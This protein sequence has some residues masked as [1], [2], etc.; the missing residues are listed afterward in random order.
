[1][2]SPLKVCQNGACEP[3]SRR[4]RRRHP[5]LS[6][7]RNRIAKTS[8]Q[9]RFLGVVPPDSGAPPVRIPVRPRPHVIGTRFDRPVPCRMPDGHFRDPEHWPHRQHAASG[10]RRSPR[11][12]TLTSK[13]LPRVRPKDSAPP[14]YIAQ[15]TI[16]NI[17]KVL[18]QELHALQKNGGRPNCE[19]AWQKRISGFPLPWS[20]L[21]ARGNP[22]RA[23]ADGERRRRRALQTCRGG[24]GARWRSRSQ[25][26]RLKSLNPGFRER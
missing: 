20:L 12:R 13:W 23:A 21:S 11:E 16:S 2:G 6:A 14:L 15:L 5:R 10:T 4:W 25:S 1:M 19:K 26:S 7:C 3:S 17:T 18:M 22:A 9:T 8:M 24:G